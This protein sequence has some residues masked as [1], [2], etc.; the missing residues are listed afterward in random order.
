MKRLLLLLSFIFTSIILSAQ[1]LCVE[2]GGEKKKSYV[3]EDGKI[4]W[5]KN[6]PINITLSSPDNPNVKLEKPFYLDTEGVNYIRTKWEMDS[7]GNYI[8]PL[9]EQTWKIY[10][11]SEPPKTKIKFISSTSYTFRGKKYYS[12][13]LT[14]K[15]IATD[16]LSGIAKTYYSVNDSEFFTYVDHVV[17]ETGIDVNIKFYSVDNVGNAENLCELEYDYDH[18]Q[19]NFGVDNQ[20]PISNVVTLDTML[21]PRDI[22]KLASVDSNGV[23]VHSI[24]Y[25]IDSG[26]F[27]VYNEQVDLFE[28]KDGIHTLQYYSLDWINNK[29]NVKEFEFYLDAIAPEIN[30]EEKILKEELTNLRHITL[31]GKDNASSLKDIYVQLHEGSEYIKYTK[32]FYID[33]SHDQIRIKAIDGVGNE[34]IRLIKYNKLKHE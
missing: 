26:D 31:I 28:L 5:N 11:D 14:I 29:E 23:G 30:I 25:K 7:T 12:D 21:S 17:F 20:A 16:E 8:Y 19:L 13:D 33:I 2:V 9:R 15:L 18:N 3:S 10:A 27:Q 4:Y 34:S 32:P 1:S 6:L 24:F 22:I